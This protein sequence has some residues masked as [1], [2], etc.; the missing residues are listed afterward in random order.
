MNRN[1]KRAIA[2][3]MII[4]LITGT[5]CGCGS[6]NKKS[7]E[8][9]RYVDVLDDNR[10]VSADAGGKEALV[11]TG[12]EASEYTLFEQ[13]LGM[14][15]SNT[16]E[17]VVDEGVSL[18]YADFD[19]D[20]V[21]KT[22][23]FET[24]REQMQDTRLGASDRDVES[25]F[26][27]IGNDGKKSLALRFN[28]MC[29]DGPDDDSYSIVFV[30]EKDGELHIT[31]SI[32]AWSRQT[33]ELS[34]IGKMLTDGA[35]GAGE[36]VS[37]CGFIGEDGAYNEMYTSYELYADWIGMEMD[38]ETYQTVFE[39]G[40]SPNIRVD[41]YDIG[42]DRVCT[43]TVIEGNE[44]GEKEKKFIELS[45]K[46]GTVWFTKEEVDTLIHDYTVKELNGSEALFEYSPDVAWK[47]LREIE[48]N[49]KVAAYYMN[50]DAD[51][52]YWN[53]QMKIGH[54]TMLSDKLSG[55]LVK[56]GSEPLTVDGLNSLK[57]DYEDIY[58]QEDAIYFVDE[59][60]D[61]NGEGYQLYISSCTNTYITTPDGKCV[62]LYISPIDFIYETLPELILEDFDGDGEKELGVWEYILHGTG[63][64]QDTF[65]I[66]DKDDESGSWNA[67]HMSSEWYVREVAKHYAAIDNGEVIDIYMDGEKV[68]EFTKEEAT[69][70]YELYGASH[71]KISGN[72]NEI[73]IKLCPMFYCEYLGMPTLCG[74][75]FATVYYDG[76]GEWRMEHISYSKETS[77][78]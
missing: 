31:H 68:D 30:G 17:A 22:Y 37:V 67:Y 50:N 9:K 6:S 11:D 56:A 44:P 34:A 65:Y 15:P 36:S 21:G 33:A 5:I 35:A 29:T 64:T 25:L 63:F 12:A 47:E 4:G 16:A 58:S 49:K 61:D 78:E 43:Y 62:K 48:A 45:E 46:D 76:P 26:S 41:M 32:S 59:R 66:I 71:V 53:Y 8:K 1:I 54:E 57:L 13:F 18:C 20:F 72:G 38:G 2:Y 19:N 24:L 77:E 14:D 3:L 39:P 75:I 55:Q 70:E 73:N 28:N 40:D 52:D 51:T 69:D 42:K 10:E 74:E 7:S 27:Y 23:S 60:F